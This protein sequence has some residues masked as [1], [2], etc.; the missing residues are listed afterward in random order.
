M[1]HKAVEKNPLLML[2]YR[3]TRDLVVGGGDLVAFQSEVAAEC[4]RVGNA[5]P[6][7]GCAA[8]LLA[9]TDALCN[10]GFY[11]L[12]ATEEIDGFLDASQKEKVLML[13][14]AIRE[15]DWARLGILVSTMAF[16]IG[17]HR[18]H[19]KWQGDLPYTA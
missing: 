18:G 6:V 3:K 17:E 8:C 19:L 10:G 2:W 4:K 16:V 14:R 12:T 7:E 1:K 15:N 13:D 9:C 11:R 5:A